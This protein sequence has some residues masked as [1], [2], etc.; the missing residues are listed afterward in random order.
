MDQ[1]D[2]LLSLSNLDPFYKKVVN[3]RF[4]RKPKPTVYGR[5]T[6]IWDL[7]V[8]MKFMFTFK[9]FLELE[10]FNRKDDEERPGETTELTKGK[11]VTKRIGH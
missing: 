5:F 3:N 6:K 7:Q 10:L 1:T 2:Y 11:K 8:T 4:G 9:F